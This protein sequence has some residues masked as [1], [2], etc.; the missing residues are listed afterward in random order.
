MVIEYLYIN[1]LKWELNLMTTKKELLERIINLEILVF[2]LLY[3]NKPIILKGGRVI[4]PP[5]KQLEL[6][7]GG[8]NA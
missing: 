6:F 5:P 4:N 2:I 3:R 1:F 8:E 7:K